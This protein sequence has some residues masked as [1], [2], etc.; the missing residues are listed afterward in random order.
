MIP[1]PLAPRA[2][3]RAPSRVGLRGIQIVEA[4]FTNEQLDLNG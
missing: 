3:G 4:H 2:L 1:V